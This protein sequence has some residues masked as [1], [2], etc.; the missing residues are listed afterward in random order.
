MMQIMTLEIK[1]FL[2]EY[3]MWL[4]MSSTWRSVFNYI[5]NFQ[6]YFYHAPSQKFQYLVEKIYKLYEEHSLIY[7]IP[8]N[9]DK[10]SFFTL[11][12]PK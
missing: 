3:K 9:I 1:I 2:S 8:K 10:T 4:T 11:I 12:H 6:V 5:E 7:E